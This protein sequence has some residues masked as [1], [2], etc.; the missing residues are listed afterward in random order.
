MA[1][2][3]VLLDPRLMPLSIIVLF[4][5]YNSPTRRG[6]FL[7]I[8][9]YYLAA[10]V[11]LISGI[12][13]FFATDSVLF[14]VGLWFAMAVLNASPFYLI[15]SHPNSRYKLVLFLLAVSTQFVPVV[16]LVSGASPYLSMGILTPS[17]GIY[18]VAC[19]Y[20]LIALFVYPRIFF[21]LFVGLYLV[22]LSVYTKPK[23][24]PAFV[25]M[26]TQIQFASSDQRSNSVP[27]WFS[28]LDYS[29]QLNTDQLLLMPETYLGV[30]NHQQKLFWENFSFL[31]KG[32]G[33]LAGA[34]LPDDK[35]KYDNV[36]LH[37]NEND[38]TPLYRQ[39]VPVPISM[40]NPFND[41]YSANAYWL[42]HGIT[43]LN[44]RRIAFMICYE[45]FLVFPFVFD[46]FDQPNYVIAAANLWW[47]M[48]ERMIKQHE[49]SVILKSRIVG[50]GYTLVINL[51][52][53]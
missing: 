48:G 42:D 7:V 11:S 41:R 45:S 13:I 34:E 8:L 26:N 53:S 6:A 18:S 39:R 4:L 9:L 28:V 17:I 14:G 37:I 21:P 1:G 52:N 20:G 36:L 3:L 43:I 46:L 10:T 16:G 33:V 49:T 12:N 22:G 35:G 38:I 29:S 19:Y 31:L 40:W 32:Q 24:D 30:F 27:R 15:R 2:W 51:P 50:G 47:T 23:E 25:A 5:S 44:N